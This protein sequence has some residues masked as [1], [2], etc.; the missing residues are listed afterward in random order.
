MIKHFAQKVEYEIPE[1]LEKLVL[2]III[3]RTDEKVDLTIPIF[4]TGFPLIVN[5][6]GDKPTYTV[7]ENPYQT[8][9]NLVVA[10]QIYNS[11][12]VFRQTGMFGNV[13][14][15]LHPAATYYLFHK[16]GKFFNNYWT[17]FRDS[18][19][20]ACC[21]LI[22]GLSDC[23][24][25]NNRIQLLLMFLSQLEKNRL[26]SIPWLENSINLILLRNGQVSQ[27]ELL[28]EAGVSVRHFRRIF[29]NVIGVP[30]KYFCKVIQLNSVFQLLHDTPS[31]KMHLLALDCGYYDQ[32]HFINDFNKFIG[33]SPENFLNGNQSY[34]KDYM[35]RLGLQA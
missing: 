25:V 20:L 17:R 14:I 10:G 2:A 13:G 27:E 19:P 22:K 21:D 23:S 12:V 24:H 28:E 5:I 35:G 8:E 4:A 29:K 16:P 31:E 3:G 32:S 33:D 11:R 18:S 26:P 6:F 34:I 9:C 15:I 7:N 1:N 30:P